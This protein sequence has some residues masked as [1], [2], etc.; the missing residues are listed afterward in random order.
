MSLSVAFQYVA[1]KQYNLFYRFET[2][3]LNGTLHLQFS[4]R[5][6]K[7]KTHKRIIIYSPP[8][9]IKFRI[10][11]ITNASYGRFV[12]FLNKTH[13]KRALLVV[14]KQFLYITAILIVRFVETQY[15]SSRLI[16]NQSRIVEFYS[17]PSGW[18][19]NFSWE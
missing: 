18:G 6:F 12:L 17:N 3:T 15:K 9:L 19:T 5:N 14:A 2:C 7:G 11:M 13:R 4:W 16:V 8:I 1:V 10:Q